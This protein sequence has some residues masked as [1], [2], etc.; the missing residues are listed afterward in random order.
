MKNKL[1]QY[2][3]IN[4]RPSNFSS[5]V[6]GCDQQR[7]VILSSIT[8]VDFVAIQ[9]VDPQAQIFNWLILGKVW[10]FPQKSSE[11]FKKLKDKDKTLNF[12]VM[13]PN[14]SLLLTNHSTNY[15]KLIML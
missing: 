8:N 3:K 7:Q 14:E 6:L 2:N 15:F 5:L 1:V 4:L 13:I 11:G 9:S 10:Y 12:L